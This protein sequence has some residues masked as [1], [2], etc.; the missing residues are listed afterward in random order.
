[1]AFGAAVDGDDLSTC[2]SGEAD[3]RTTLVLKQQ[4]AEADIGSFIHCHRGTQ[5]V[6]IGA[7]DCNL[8]HRATVLDDLST[9]TSDW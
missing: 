1:M 2:R 6:K 5:F 3:A 7:D 8:C 9:F 4:L